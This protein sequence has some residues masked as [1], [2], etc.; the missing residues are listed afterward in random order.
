MTLDQ[1]LAQSWERLELA[2][3]A[4]KR[5]QTAI[6]LDLMVAAQGDSD[7]WTKQRDRLVKLLKS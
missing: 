1:A 3:W 4:R 6:M 5:E 7:S 2:A